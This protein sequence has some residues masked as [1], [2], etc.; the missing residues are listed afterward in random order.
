MSGNVMNPVNQYNFVENKD[1]TISLSHSVSARGINTVSYPSKSNA[2][3]NAIAFVRQNTGLANIP[4]IKFISGA[5]NNFYL[6]N[7]SESID[8]LN[9]IYSVDESYTSS[10]LDTGS[11]GILK[12]S[13]DISSG[14]AADSLSLSI[15]G[16]Y[17]GPLGGNVNDLRNSLNVTKL[18]S[19]SYASY[20]NPIPINYSIS[21]NTGENII[22]FDYSF[23]N[24]NLPNPYFK[25]DTSVE[26]DDI[27]Q[28]IKVDINASIIARGNRNNRYLLSQANQASLNSSFFTIA[29]GAVLDFK[30]FNNDT[31]SYKLRLQNMEFIDNPNEGIITAKVSY[32]D[33]PM[34]SGDNAAVAD[35][36]FR[37]SVQLPC[38]YMAGIPVINQRGKY[39]VNDFN[40]NTLPKCTVESSVSVKDG[41]SQNATAAIESNIQNSIRT[42]FPSDYNYNLTVKESLSTEKAN[43]DKISN[44]T[45]PILNT[46]NIN[47]TIEKISTKH[48]GSFFPKIYQ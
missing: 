38:F 39:I 24:I 16:S 10:L 21:E 31:G 36:S 9:A 8:R 17:K 45:Q 32:D 33:K 2:L 23:D 47:Y 26:K 15:K 7:I 41:T 6:Q 11:S 4:T 30:D 22:N 37:V 14:V 48:E 42:I 43:L 35:S 13:I 28:V 1:K 34:P 3:E 29:S 19:G 5:S 44:F 46:K 40:I 18:V 27:E 25:Y 12:Y 20:F